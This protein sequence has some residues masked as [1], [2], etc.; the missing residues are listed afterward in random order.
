MHDARI[1]VSQWGRDRL[2]T[3]GGSD[4]NAYGINDSGEVVG[5]ADT[6]TATHAFVYSDG[7]MVDLNS[8]IDPNAGWVLTD[9]FAINDGG[10]IVGDGIN[11][12]GKDD[13]FL[14]TPVSTVPEPNWSSMG[15]QC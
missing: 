8:L 3:L 10:L 2:G 14:L 5:S 15:S 1:P 6:G 13:A 4:S 12:E 7:T 11:P 9:A